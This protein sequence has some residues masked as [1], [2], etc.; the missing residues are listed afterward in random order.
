MFVSTAWHETKQNN[1]EQISVIYKNSLLCSEIENYYN[2][3]QISIPEFDKFQ[4]T[5]NN[6]FNPYLSIIIGAASAAIDY[7]NSKKNDKK[8]DDIMNSLR[9]VN[10]K[11]DLIVDELGKMEIN[12][13]NEIIQTYKTSVKNELLAHIATLDTYIKYPGGPDID[14]LKPNF[15]V[16]SNII[17]DQI[18]DPYLYSIIGT[19]MIVH[20]DIFYLRRNYQNNEAQAKDKFEKYYEYF[21][22]TNNYLEALIKSEEPAQLKKRSKISLLKNPIAKIY[23]IYEYDIRLEPRAMADFEL[24]HI[25][26][27]TFTGTEQ[28]PSWANEQNVSSK[29]HFYNGPFE[30]N[31]SCENEFLNC[32]EQ[33]PIGQVP[34]LEYE[35]SFN[36]CSDLFGLCRSNKKY[37]IS[38]LNKMLKQSKMFL[39][40]AERWK[41]NPYLNTEHLEK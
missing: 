16:L 36:K 2:N 40:I 19:A 30:V 18:G 34:N 11:L 17:M 15:E 24:Y 12:I 37:N 1:F 5:A 23:Y 22:L 13:K 10:Q 29:Y 4:N 20:H 38:E 14:Y 33:I 27:R 6:N 32:I 31:G 28:R 8:L 21:Q 26:K 25:T 41:I 3:D 7:G 35:N 39:E 9:E